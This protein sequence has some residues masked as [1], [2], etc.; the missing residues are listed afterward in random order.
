MKKLLL[1]ALLGTLV[2]PAFSQSV[3]VVTPNGGENLTIGCPFTIQWTTSTAVAVKIELYRNDAFYMTIVSQVP[4]GQ[5]NYT[6]TPTPNAVTGNIYKI[7]VTALTT[8]LPAVFD[9]SDNPFSIGNGSLTVTSPNGG[10][11]WQ[12]GSTHAITW[13]GT[14]CG[15]VRIELWKGGVYNSLITASAPSN[16]S[17]SWTILTAATVILDGNDFKVKILS[18]PNASGA[19]SV[20]SDFSDAN[21]TIS[22]ATPSPVI[23][24]NTPN[25]GENWIIGC[26]AT[27]QWTA[28]IPVPVKVELFKD[29]AFY[30][31]IAGQVAASVNTCTWIPPYYTV[32]GSSFKVKVTALTSAVPVSDFSNNPFTISQGSITVTS[33]NGGEIWM[34]GSTYTIKWADNI[35]EQVRIELWKG[36]IFKSLITAATPSTGTYQWVIAATNTSIIPGNDYKIKI[37]STTTVAGSTSS[38]YDFSNANFTIGYTP[39]VPVLTVLTPNG[40]ETWVAGCPG[41]ITWSSTIPVPV[42]IDLYKNDIYYLTLSLQVSANITSISWTPSAT[43]PAG[44]IYKV[45]VSAVTVS[46]SSDFSDNNF[47]ITSGSITVTSPNGGEVWQIGTT[48]PITWNTNLCGNVR[49]E[50]WK[51]GVYNSLITPGAT[52]GG[53]YLWTIL[54]PTTAAGQGDDYKVKVISLANS[55]GTAI[56]YDFSDNNFTIANGNYAPITVISPNGGEV[57]SVGTTSIIRWTDYIPQNVTIELWK[58]GVFHSIINQS[59]PSNGSCYWAIPVNL[60]LGSDYKV[61]IWAPGSSAGS[62]VFDFS[63]NNFTIAGSKSK[64]ISNDPKTS[65]F[66]VIYPNPAKDKIYVN[67][68]AGQLHPSIAEIYSSS[69]VMMLTQGLPAYEADYTVAVDI[70]TLTNGVYL[71]VL[72]QGENILYRSKLAVKQ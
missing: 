38:V 64:T 53:P 30:M 5:V 36:G 60:P 41:T 1:F 8:N 28:S 69:G 27:I 44:N 45:K 37:M 3:T 65:A 32:A 6:W 24:V 56:K 13:T 47:A 40:G 31:T 20:V 25:G 23:T 46:S 17:Y 9:I 15:N 21:F 62:M 67:L 34:I 4:A 54:S 50:L 63:D 35:C 39:P 10:E 19:T 61:K 66:I 26:P 49:I 70:T 2:L 33:P 16:A 14:I 52:A 58:G 29:N 48:H 57:L 42:K 55:A 7:K 12:A 11:V 18:A 22:P 43:V 59:A 68:S 71:L 72:R 51:G